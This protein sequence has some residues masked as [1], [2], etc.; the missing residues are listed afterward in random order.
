M[1]NQNIIER[2]VGANTPAQGSNAIPS[3]VPTGTSAFVPTNQAGT[4]AVVSVGTT[5]YASGAAT[6][7]SFGVNFDG[8]AF[9]LRI[10]G[11][12][13]TGAACNVTVA[14]QTGSSTTVTAANSVATTA[15]TAVNT[16][17]QNF[18]LEA[19]CLWDGVSQVINGYQVGQIANTAV[20][21]GALTHA[22]SVTTQAGLV[23]VP[24]LT[25]SAT[26]GAT[27]TI[28]EFVAETV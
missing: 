28:T 9:K 10:A 16:T 24:V 8:F 12:V 2:L 15:A 21:Y 27:M 22:V 3:I 14:I 1:P 18:L 6:A 7:P 13:T 5:Q 20:T 4:A 17:S 26:T 11:K 25:F 19:V 23:F